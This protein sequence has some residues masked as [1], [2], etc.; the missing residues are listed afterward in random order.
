ME[1]NPYPVYDTQQVQ[2][3]EALRAYQFD[4]DD[5]MVRW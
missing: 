5:E 4:W 1:G 2:A 3:Q